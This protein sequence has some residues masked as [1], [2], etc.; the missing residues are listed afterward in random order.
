[1]SRRNAVKGRPDL[2]AVES[3]VVSV[4]MPSSKYGPGTET[5]SRT[6][7]RPQPRHQAG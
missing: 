4:T 2:G 3:D 5:D 7:A 6:G 1:M